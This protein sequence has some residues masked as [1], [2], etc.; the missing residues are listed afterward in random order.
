MI[1]SDPQKSKE[2]RRRCSVGD[3]AF[4]DTRRSCPGESSVHPGPGDRSARWLESQLPVKQT[5]A[6]A[7]KTSRRE[8]VHVSKTST[9]E[10]RVS[11]HLPY[12]DVKRPS[13]SKTPFATL[14]I[15]FESRP[16]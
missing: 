13:L 8:D 5:V 10:L 2:E 12:K 15:K 16:L 7:V 6:A 1:K 11:R 14:V 4:S 9:D 3:G